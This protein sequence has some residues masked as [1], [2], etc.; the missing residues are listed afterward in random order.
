MEATLEHAVFQT[1]ALLVTGAGAWLIYS[2]RG[3]RRW[4]RIGA[5]V[6]TAGLIWQLGMIWV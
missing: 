2:S 6:L 3:N 4:T 1:T 5:A